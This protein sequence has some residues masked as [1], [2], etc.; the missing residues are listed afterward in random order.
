[1]GV[2]GFLA[3]IDQASRYGAD[4]LLGGGATTCRNPAGTA[5]LSTA[6]LLAVADNQAKTVLSVTWPVE[7]DWIGR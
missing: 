4:R 2:C 3:G 7:V 6:R 1:M 5:I